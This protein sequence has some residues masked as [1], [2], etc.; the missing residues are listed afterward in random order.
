MNILLRINHKY[1]DETCHVFPSTNKLNE[2]CR[3][4]ICLSGPYI[5]KHFILKSFSFHHKK[6]K[7]FFLN[8]LSALPPLADMST[9]FCNKFHLDREGGEWLTGKKFRGL[10]IMNSMML[11]WVE[12]PIFSAGLLGWSLLFYI[13]FWFYHFSF[14]RK[15]FLKIWN[16]NVCI[17]RAHTFP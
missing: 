1:N 13:F 9:T 8:F 14:L 2:C 4:F 7:I 3:Y 15:C 5:W 12:L 6:N 16:V 17:F 11:N 10:Q